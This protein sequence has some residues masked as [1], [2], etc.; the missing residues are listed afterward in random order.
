MM[1]VKSLAHGKNLIYANYCCH[2]P[3]FSLP[4]RKISL[5][6]QCSKRKTNTMKGYLCSHLASPS[7]ELFLLCSKGQLRV[8]IHTLLWR[9]DGCPSR[10]F[11]VASQQVALQDSSQ[12]LSLVPSKAVDLGLCQEHV[13]WLTAIL[14]QNPHLKPRSLLTDTAA[15]S[16][17]PERS[18]G[19]SGLSR[20]YTITLTCLMLHY[21]RAFADSMTSFLLWKMW[22]SPSWPVQVGVTQLVQSPR[23]ASVCLPILKSATLQAVS[24]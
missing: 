21:T 14:P 23:N 16:K 17:D 6:R 24:V 19:H 11:L 3:S 5:Q 12:Q 2:L 4:Q 18:S 1:F 7:L 10:F 20:D 15:N 22:V 8:S 9:K 13:I